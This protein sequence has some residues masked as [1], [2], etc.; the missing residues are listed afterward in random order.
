MRLVGILYL[1]LLV[2]IGTGNAQ[3]ISG[4][5]KD[6][7]TGELLI[8]VN[9]FN[10]ESVGAATNID[11]QYTLKLTPGEHTVTFKFIG[12]QELK[13]KFKL[14]EGETVTFNA[15]LP[16]ES[17]T[18][19]L[20]V[21]TGS[22]FEKK[23][24][25]EMVTIDVIQDY[26]IE[27]TASPD[28]KAAVSKVPGV[29]I[30]DGQVSIRGGSGYSYGV[31]SRVQLVVDGLPLLTGDLQDIQWSAIPME[32]AQQIEVVKG[33][34]SSLYG[35]GAMNGVIHVRTGWAKDKPETEFRIYQGIYDTPK[36]EEARWWENT[37][38]PA[39]T[40]VFLSHRRK[41]KNLDL[42]VGAHASSDQTYLQRGHRQAARINLKTR[43]KFEKIKG[44]SAGING[45]FQ[46]QQSGR[47]ILWKDSQEGAYIPLD[48]TSSTDKYVMAN[49]DPYIQY[50]SDVV[51]THTLRMRYYMVERRNGSFEDPSTS[52]VMFF[53]YRFQKDF[54]YNFN[55]TSGIQY[56]YVWSVSTLY[57]DAGTV[58]THN[59]A[60]YAQVEKRFKDK[61]SVLFGLRS[62]YYE[63]PGLRS[64]WIQTY[65][66]PD[67]NMPLIFRFG[68]NAKLAKKTNLRMSFGQSFRF[69]SIGEK[70][71][72]ASLGVIDIR[73]EQD[74]RPEQGWS[75]ELGIKQGFRILSW[76][77]NFDAAL[78]WSDYRDMIEYGLNVD[79]S[80]IYFKP[81][82]ISKARVAGFELGL[83]G[84]G[85]LGPIPMRVYLGYTFNY[86]ADLQSD[87]T[88]ENFGIY[89]QNLFTSIS[90]PD[91]LSELS[92]LKYRI[93]NVFKADIEMDLWKFTLGY[94]VEYTSYMN[95]IDA[96]F[97]ALL[98]GFTEYRQL[99]NKGV[100]RM[101]LRLG[102]K[103]A[104]NQ[105]V[106]I[107]AKNLLNEFYSVRPGIMEPPRSFTIQYKLKI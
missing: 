79:T 75:A 1:A 8:G 106:A 71:V 11:G 64:D 37:F 92:I 23:L 105:T 68:L 80:G 63:T 35:S 94:T 19:D 104:K 53:D 97:E 27:N 6:G 60:F 88:Q 49:V 56:Q 15:E 69:P 14:K 78:F 46:F 42:V 99:H 2:F 85:N 73:P 31:G 82:N 52:N 36:Y 74:L 57:P 101:D 65:L 12:F 93:A 20:V 4:T 70:Y 87:T 54:K 100:W 45:N 61:V 21:V 9:V 30:L 91:S 51:G 40:G 77:A 96:S 50:L 62:E 90:N 103:V 76:H 25:E 29:T 84:D 24:E 13:K 86:P 32:T 98:P 66:G 44:L 59:P 33:S 72:N 102:V 26:L 83:Q 39:F 22:Q 58:V 16:L 7:S 41:I 10:Q 3:T 5:V 38:S 28:L 95:R 55:L 17:T 81:Q 89:M 18:L 107:I 48:G 43:Y 47:F 67:V 34:S